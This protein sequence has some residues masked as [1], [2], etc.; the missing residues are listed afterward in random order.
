MPETDSFATPQNM[1]DRTQGQITAASHPFL[2]RELDAATEDIRNFC[3]WHV[4]PVRALTYRRV[5]RYA[6]DVWLP[7][8][9]IESIDAVTIDG[10]VWDAN[11]LS[12][13]EFDP[14]S[15][16]TNLCGRSVIIG[17]TAGFEKVPANLITATLELAA[18][19]LGTSLG[20]EKEQA[21]G[22]SVTFG[23]AGGGIDE[24]SIGGQRLI[25]YRIGRLP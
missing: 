2:Q 11:A 23:H 10:T 21:G 22:V 18:G 20:Y 8:M 19:A 12:A 3:R 17:Y 13:V 14:D 24:D 6:D 25:A 1:A 5:G 9:N 16:W 7:A 15:G 4:A